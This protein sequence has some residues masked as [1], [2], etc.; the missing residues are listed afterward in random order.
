MISFGEAPGLTG[1]AVAFM[2]TVHRG[3]SIFGNM[4]SS[5]LPTFSCAG[6]IREVWKAPEVF[7]TFACKAPALSANSLSLVIAARVPATEKPL[8]KSSLAIPQTAEPP[9]AFAASL[10]SSS[11]LGLSRPATESIACLLMLAASFMAS[12]RSFTSF[13]PSSKLKTP[14][15]QRAVYSPNERPAMTWQR[16]TASSRS[17]RSFSTPA[18]PA[19]NIAGWQFCVSSSLSSGP[20]KHNFNKS[21]PRMVFALASMSWT[22]ARSLQVD[23]IF[24]YWE[25]WPGKR[26]PMGKG[27]ADGAGADSATEPKS[28]SSSSGSASSPPPYFL[29]SIPEYLEAPGRLKNQPFSGFFPQAKEPYTLALAFF[30][31]GT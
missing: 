11:S 4:S 2:Y 3:G 8:G 19:M 6:F 22:G 5:A 20:S 18:R 13:S 9:S 30:P 15:A 28:M 16:V 24:T 17:V 26:R 25:P 27:F 23:I 14:A 29:G 10:Q 21:K 7:N 12:P 31:A 1:L